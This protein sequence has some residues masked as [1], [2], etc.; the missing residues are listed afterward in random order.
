MFKTP[1]NHGLRLATSLEKRIQSI[2]FLTK[3]DK[4]HK[5]HVEEFL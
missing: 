2:S 5:T 4:N 1:L 3:K